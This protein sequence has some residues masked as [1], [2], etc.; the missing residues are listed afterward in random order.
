MARGDF[1]LGVVVRPVGKSGRRP[2]VDCYS[3]SSLGIILQSRRPQIRV[4]D[5]ALRPVGKELAGRPRGAGWWVEEGIL[6]KAGWSK[7]NSAR[8][9]QSK[10][11]KERRLTTGGGLGA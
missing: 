9:R 11:R 3:S 10:E 7:Q 5:V 1:P 6:T 2:E 8:R 4:V